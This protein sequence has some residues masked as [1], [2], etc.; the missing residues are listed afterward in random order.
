[1][2]PVLKKQL[3]LAAKILIVLAVVSW[4]AWELRKSWDKA[5]LI[6]WSPDYFWLTMAGVFYAVGYLP[7]ALFWR[8][9][10]QT[11]GQAPGFYES[12][13]A[14]YIG[15]LGKYI[16][17]KAMV[18]IIRSG[19]LDHTKTHASVAAAA[20][21]L[22]TLTMMA[23]G[24][25][26]AALIILLYRNT[27]YGDIP[28]GNYLT[29][30]AVGMMIAAGLPIF[31]PF[32]R[33]VARKLGVGKKDPEIDA[34]LAGLTLKT[35]LVGWVLLI[36]AWFLLGL[37]LWASIRGIGIEAEPLL[38]VLPRFT[39][40]AAFSM[41]L[42]F[43]LMVPGGLGVRE[44]AMAQV[45]ITY[46]AAHPSDADPASQAIVVAGVQRIVSILTE[47]FI[48]ALLWKS[49]SLPTESTG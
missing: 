20:V 32:F 38:D 31:P 9:S 12:L 11:L 26:L 37:S 49:K 41:V 30:L 3:I 35:L 19:L 4:V 5:S 48:S 46:F 8:Y 44:F 7:A 13:R 14:Y 2:N 45:L 29:L 34:K 42:G 43:V 47:L 24:A 17:G 16:P 6:Q 36:P 40:A 22:E 33:K 23:V 15:H 18:V 21:F 27:S 25:F 39:L 10:M 28:H 1:M